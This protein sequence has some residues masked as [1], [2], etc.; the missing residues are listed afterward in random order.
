[1]NW[2][3]VVKEEEEKEEKIKEE[4]VIEINSVTDEVRCCTA[5]SLPETIEEEEYKDQEKEEEK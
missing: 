2:V 3:N 4:A 5:K 1:M